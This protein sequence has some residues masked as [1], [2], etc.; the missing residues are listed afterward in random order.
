MRSPV[1]RSPLGEC[2]AIKSWGFG[3]RDLTFDLNVKA[4]FQ[5]RLDV[6]SAPNAKRPPREPHRGDCQDRTYS[7]SRS[8]TEGSTSGNTKATRRR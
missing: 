8:R 3:E 4:A 6:T 5:R 7:Q 1:S 2:N